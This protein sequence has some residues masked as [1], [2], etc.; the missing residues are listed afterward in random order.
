MFGKQV[1][2]APSL[3]L[4]FIP[5]GPCDRLR[6]KIGEDSALSRT[7]LKSLLHEASNGDMRRPPFAEYV[8]SYA[9]LEVTQPLAEMERLLGENKDIIERAFDTIKRV[10]APLS[11]RHLW[12]LK[13]E[14][15]RL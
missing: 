4:A 5:D 3:G 1:Q 13:G 7:E 14:I 2:N 11:K 9:L 10:Y 8:R 6:Q 12:S 15:R